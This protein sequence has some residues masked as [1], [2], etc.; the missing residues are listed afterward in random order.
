LAEAGL[1]GGQRLVDG[2]ELCAGDLSIGS[3]LDAL[4]DRQVHD[5]SLQRGGVPVD[6]LGAIDAA[7]RQVEGLLDIV[8]LR[9]GRGT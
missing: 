5:P 7:E 1:P 4:E 6:L 9:D 8:Q 3:N 2:R